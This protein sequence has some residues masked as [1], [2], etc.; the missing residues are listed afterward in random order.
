MEEIYK[1]IQEFD[2][3]EVSNTGN[4]RN[5]VSHKILIPWTNNKGYL[6]VGL[7]KKWENT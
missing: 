2:K 3:Y 5:V 1:V 7:R 6:V 4:I